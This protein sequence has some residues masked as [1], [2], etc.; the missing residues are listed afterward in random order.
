MYLT[1]TSKKKILPLSEKLQKK[2]ES[3]MKTVNRGQP[4]PRTPFFKELVK[5]FRPMFEDEFVRFCEAK[6]RE[7]ELE[8]PEDFANL[9]QTELLI[10]LGDSYN[11]KNF[12]FDDEKGE[13]KQAATKEDKTELTKYL[14]EW[15]IG[16]FAELFWNYFVHLGDYGQ[17]DGLP[18]LDKDLLFCIDAVRMR[19]IMTFNWFLF[20]PE[21][22][23]VK[24]KQKKR[25]CLINCDINKE[26]NISPK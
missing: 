7:H 23:Q 6:Q 16:N 10:L 4:R 13:G 15:S 19:V 22:Y 9:T 12:D 3:D 20:N 14:Y 2:F 5:E 8:S 17:K 25:I 21:L 18:F 1:A 26:I 24:I 11:A